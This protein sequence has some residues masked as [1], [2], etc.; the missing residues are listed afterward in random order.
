MNI[1]TTR[2]WQDAFP[3][4]HVGTLLVGNID[5]A[6]RV[7][8]LD[9]RKRALET[10]LRAE[11][12]HLSRAELLENEVLSA[13]RAYYKGFDQTYH[14]QLQLES[15]VHK[16]KALP[17]VS[18]LVDASF[19]AEM[20]TLVLTASHDADRLAWPLSIDVTSGKESFEQMNGKVRTLK[21]GDMMMA[22]AQ[23]IVCTIL[24][25]QDRRTP[26][27][28]VT[29][30]TLFVCYA[31]SGVAKERVRQQLDTILTHVRLFAPA[32]QVEGLEIFAAGASP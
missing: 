6:R 10:R 32:A 30:R 21:R 22:D 14:V 20:E 2:A 26:V 13:Y 11:F 24:Y 8:R 1:Q 16:D 4:G 19:L 17:N 7:T 31:P 9:E 3:D 12:G 27:S 28:E 5:N 23:G 15:V 25:G 29:R 18:P